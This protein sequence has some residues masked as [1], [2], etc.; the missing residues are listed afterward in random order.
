MR[1]DEDKVSDKQ[2]WHPLSLVDPSP[3]L[4]R[5]GDSHMDGDDFSHSLQNDTHTRGG[6]NGE[7]RRKMRAER[8]E[9]S[10]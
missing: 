4:P 6:M 1:G 10:K 3:S 2:G 8:V 7:E 9:K 5:Q